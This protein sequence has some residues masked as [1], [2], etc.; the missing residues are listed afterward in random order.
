M[1]F[2]A[3]G[4]V[5][6]LAYDHTSIRLVSSRKPPK[7]IKNYCIMTGFIPGRSHIKKNRCSSY[8]LGVEKAIL[9]ALRVFSLKSGNF[10]GTF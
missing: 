2:S 9:V 6:R 3:L 4:A 10:C 8:L 5:H 7:R 1:R